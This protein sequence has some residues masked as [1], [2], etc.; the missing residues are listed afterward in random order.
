MH[1]IRIFEV[2]PNDPHF[3][4]KVLELMAKLVVGGVGNTYGQ[5]LGFIDYARRFN[6]YRE[7]DWERSKV[8]LRDGVLSFL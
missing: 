8:M 5:G 3:T 1:R 6:H 7:Y 2:E 4:A